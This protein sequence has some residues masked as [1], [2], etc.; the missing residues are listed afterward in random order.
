MVINHLDKLFVTNDA[1]T[2]MKEMEIA[3]PAARILV[4][5]AQQQEQEIGDATNFVIVFAGELLQKA[6]QLLRIGLHTADVIEGFEVAGKQVLKMLEDVKCD[7]I[8][9]LK[10]PVQLSK[11]VRPCIGSKQYGYDELLT[12]LV[13]EA[14]CDIMP[15]NPKNFNVDNVRVVKIMGGSIHD[16]KVVRG[17][18]FGREPEG[19]IKNVKKAK[20]AIFSCALDIQQTETKGTVLLKNAN[21]LLNF[22]KGMILKNNLSNSS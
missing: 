9:N 19:D 4:L 17:M 8:T 22:S 3:H 14:C 15:S 20:V 5:A 6:E 16:T 11:A 21:E 13:V 18:V 1:A 12:K 10:D 2:M 7:E